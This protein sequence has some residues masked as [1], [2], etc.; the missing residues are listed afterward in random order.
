MTGIRS[1][2][3]NVFVFDNY[4]SA[5]SRI[6]QEGTARNDG[7]TVEIS[8]T[9]R[10][11][12]S[13]EEWTRI[14]NVNIRRHSTKRSPHDQ[15]VGTLPDKALDMMKAHVSESALF[16]LLHEDVLSNIDL[17]RYPAVADANRTQSLLVL[18]GAAYAD[19]AI[20]AAPKKIKEPDESEICAWIRG[21]PTAA[22]FTNEQCVVMHM[23]FQKQKA[24]GHSP[25]EARKRIGLL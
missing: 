19:L 1:L 3:N 24:A 14:Q 13:T 5:W 25:L 12:N 20:N 8:L 23:E 17:S 16:T 15:F 9:A 7:F 10:H 21:F 22:L 2:N 11:R 6:L 4:W 18:T